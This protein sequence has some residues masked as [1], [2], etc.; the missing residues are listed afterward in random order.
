MKGTGL[1]EFYAVAALEKL[2]KYFNVP[3]DKQR[4]VSAVL[5]CRIDASGRISN[6]A[7]VQ[8]SGDSELDGFA[9]TAL[10]RCQ[11][12]SPFPD[13]FDKPHVDVEISF[14]FRQ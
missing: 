13:S 3:P 12:F 14:T 2:A 9:R 10:E 11:T 1:P 7:V 5:R 8:S 4:E 6:I